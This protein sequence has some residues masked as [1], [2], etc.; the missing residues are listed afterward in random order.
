[1]SNALLSSKIVITEEP[2]RIQSFTA[3]PTAVLGMVGLAERGPMDTA[4]LVTSFE[5]FAT[6]FG[7]YTLD[8]KDTTAA[9]EGY[10]EEGGQFLWFV[11]TARHTD[12]NDPTSNEALTASGEA[13]TLAAI[14]APPAVTG[15]LVGPFSLVDGDTLTVSLNGAPGVTATFNAGPASVTATAPGTYALATRASR[16][17][18]N[19]QPF[20]LTN[21]N[22]LLISIDGEAA[23][24]VTFNTADFASI[25]AATAAEV[26]AVILA[27]TT[28]IG[29]S[30]GV[31]NS[32]VITNAR[33]LLNT[34]TIQVTGGTDAAAL[35]FPGT[36]ATGTGDGDTLTVSIDGEAD[37]TYTVR[38]ADFVNIEAA[39]ALEVATAITSQLVDVV[40]SVVSNTV[41][42]TNSRGS[43][44]GFDIEV[45]GGTTTG[46]AFPPGAVTGTGDAADATAVSVS[47]LATLITGDIAGVAVT[48]VSGQ[49]RI[50]GLVNGSTQTLQ[51]LNTSTLDVKLGLSRLVAFGSDAA[52]ATPTLAINAKYPGEYGNDVVVRIVQASSLNASEFDLLVL[53]DGFVREQFNNLTMDDT[54]PN[55]VEEAINASPANGG[56]L[57][58]SVADL[59]AG[60]GSALLDRPANGDYTLSGGTNGLANIGDIDFIGSAVGEN[61]LRALD[62]AGDLTLL[63][64][65]ARAT[66]AVHNAMLNYAEVT[67]NGTVFAVLDPPANLTAQEMVTYVEQQA[68]LLESSE[69][70]AIYFPRVKVLNP[71]TTLFGNVEAITVPPS[72]HVAGRYARTD[73]SQ[74]GGIYQPPAGLTNGRL[75]TIVG[76]EIL[77]NA[78]VPETFDVNK[79][80]LLYPKR[81]NP[82]SE[83]T[84][85]R[86]LDGVRTLKSSG[87]F[88][89]IAERR[90][91]IFIEVTT[92]RNLQSA[93]FRNN[94]ATLRAEVSRA[95]EAFLLTQMQVGAF[96]SRDPRKAFSVDF[97]AGLNPPSVVFAGQL[98]GRIGL[99]TQKPA[100]FIILRFTQ[101]T[102][103][104]E[105]ELSQP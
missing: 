51:V 48:N 98:V 22:T 5:E 56:S 23:Q 39:T 27:Q 64:V 96:R 44:T 43:G 46:I 12:I 77:A 30:V 84:G 99:A 86:I 25:G 11:R 83:L 85:G 62:V 4:V 90:G 65:P 40:A 20:A 74:P 79:R 6:V 67:R 66:A 73:G 93:R 57:L 82:I 92:K 31:G 89:T 1:M 103:A 36:A 95:V 68:L 9:V 18:G 75:G 101:D 91:V 13:D 21:G 35:A 104:L 2:P 76:L 61:G 7:G 47:E 15:N 37:Q 58:I 16:T 55:F 88:P 8:T 70:G 69:F 59:A 49:V 78:E 80:D 60:L 72:G 54:L 26:V 41:V 50:A 38:I 105:Q 81:I 45:T 63:A 42:L 28:D 24:T 102:R 53:E 10:F 3:L 19:T 97:G 17:S 71:N 14:A 32:V 34:R 87:N 52:T 29:A 94:D 100:E 33:S